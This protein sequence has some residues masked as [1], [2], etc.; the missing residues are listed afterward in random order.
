MHELVRHQNVIPDRLSFLWLELTAKCQLECTHCYADSGPRGTHGSMTREDWTRVID[1]AHELGVRTILFIGGEPMLHPHLKEL[2]ERAARPG[3][4]VRVLS[5][6]VHVPDALWEALEMPGVRLSVSY[7]SHDA[8][9]HDNMTRRRGSHLRTTENLRKAVQRGVQVRAMIVKESFG[10]SGVTASGE[11][12]ALEAMGVSRHSVDRV[13]HLGRAASGS[14]PRSSELC[15]Q[16]SG[17]LL[18]VGPDGT[19]FPCP[20]SR[21]LRVG[22]VREGSLATLVASSRLGAARRQIAEAIDPA[23]TGLPPVMRNEC[24]GSESGGG[25]G[26]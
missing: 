8:A 16:C 5:N 11:I 18:A 19:A 24:F 13:R 10:E 2:I 17:E 12:A 3:I 21:W 23:V 25:C 14:A 26:P 9:A 6:L 22:N 4:E 7:Y 20:M 15:G 1:E